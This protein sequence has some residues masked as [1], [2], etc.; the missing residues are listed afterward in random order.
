MELKGL[1]ILGKVQHAVMVFA[2]FAIRMVCVSVCEWSVE[3]NLTA[4]YFNTM[5]PIGEII[6]ESNCIRTDHIIEGRPTWK[7]GT[8]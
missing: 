5:H 1:Q 3:T 2:A 4:G 6:I 7:R 8:R